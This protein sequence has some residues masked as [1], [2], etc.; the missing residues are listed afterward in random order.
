MATTQP[1]SSADRSAATATYVEV[2]TS[3]GRLRGREV[4][5]IKVF[6]GIEYGGSTS[7]RNRFMPPTKPAPWSGVRD[8]IEFGRVAPQPVGAPSEY[9]RLIGW[10]N[11]PGGMGEE[12]LVLNLWTP[13]LGDGR[14]RPVMVSIH[15]G[16]FTS[17]SGSTPGYAGATLSRFGDVV[18]ITINHR[19]GA[20]G[21]LHLGDLTSAPE[22]AQSGTVGML[23]IVAALEW[24]RDN[25]E[26]FG[27]D[28]DN[29]MVF[30]QSGG[31]AKT[32]ALMAMPSA[33]GMFHRA[34]VQ[35]GSALRLMTRELASE[36]AERLLKQLGL[37]KNRLAELQDLPFE[38]VVEAQGSLA[39]GGP[40]LGF[41]PVVD[42]TAIPR[43]PFDPTAPE[44][45]AHVPLIIGTTLD[46]SAM[47]GGK[48][49]MTDADLKASL[50]K[51]YQD[52]AD[53]IVATYRRFYPD[54]S[55]FLL[56]ARMTTDRRGRR[57]AST[58]AE[59]K[60]AQGAAPAYLY[61]FN[62]PSPAFGGKFGA[63]HGVDVGLAFANA[64]GAMAGDTPEARVLAKRFGSAW[65]A[66]AR[67]GNPNNSEIPVWPEYDAATRPT[68]LFDNEV[69]TEFDP[70]RELRTMW[71]EIH[72]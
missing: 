15:G 36:Q 58:Q 53:R 44:V 16:G 46:D 63:V 40:M 61:L 45:S 24:V 42:G 7:G 68:M 43:H 20:L 31:G 18:A 35:S 47:G 14:K 32:S 64:R 39:P 66:F 1:E 33:K 26:R 6:K 72:S 4:N 10:D 62:W 57:A 8:A 41:S 30:G 9:G 49:D 69:K 56:R 38:K 25:A 55:A 34:A 17:G 29:V 19:L 54:A 65:V 11:Q 3:Y 70:L 5:G 28:P 48:F 27:G 22:F 59:R 21:Y 71:N 51:R 23:D 2:E 12:C 13:G 52:N 67:T 60:A 50:Q 37:D